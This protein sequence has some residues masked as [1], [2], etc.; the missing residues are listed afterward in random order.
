METLLPII[1]FAS[2]A[3]CTMGAI[4]CLIRNRTLT[5]IGSITTSIVL[6]FYGKKK[7]PIFIIKS[8]QLLQILNKLT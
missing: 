3:S 2:T 1:F 5:L 7:N 4:G 6:G 8:I